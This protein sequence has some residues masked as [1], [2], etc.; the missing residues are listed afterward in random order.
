MS[1]IANFVEI[2]QGVLG[3]S[4]LKFG[5]IGVASVN[6]GTARF[7]L[8]KSSAVSEDSTILDLIRIE[9]LIPVDILFV[10]FFQGEL[11]FKID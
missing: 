10:S 9:F 3:N 11:R 5:L 2:K 1:V 8:R 6:E 7:S 4:A